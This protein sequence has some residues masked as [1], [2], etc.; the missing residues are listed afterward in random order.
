MNA[1][2]VWCPDRGETEKEATEIHAE[3]PATAA[4]SWARDA[5]D[6]GEDDRI[7]GGQGVTVF[8][9]MVFATHRYIVSGETASTYR[10][11][12]I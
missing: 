2:L 9:K 5:D 1:W 3:S 10:A 11:R 12:K 6:M 8:V 4:E 7:E